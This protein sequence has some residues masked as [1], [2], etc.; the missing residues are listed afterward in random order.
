MFSKC[1]Y[2]TRSNGLTTTLG[3][4]AGAHQAALKLS[5]AEGIPVYLAYRIAK[6]LKALEVDL[7]LIQQKRNEIVKSVIA[8]LPEGATEIAPDTQQYG[9]FAQKFSELLATET[10]LD[11]RL[12]PL[13]KFPEEFKGLTPGDIMAL[14]GIVLHDDTDDPKPVLVDVD[15]DVA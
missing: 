5:Q 10:E 15:K 8:T 11:V 1:Y 4:I 13:S 7:D 14:D 12:I 6:S 9:D 3:R 2:G